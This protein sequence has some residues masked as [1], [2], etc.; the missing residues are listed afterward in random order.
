MTPER[1]GKSWI[2]K[3]LVVALILIGMWIWGKLG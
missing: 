2:V 1:E 3:A